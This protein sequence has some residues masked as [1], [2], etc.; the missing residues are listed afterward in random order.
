VTF[1]AQHEQPSCDGESGS[2]VQ[3]AGAQCNDDRCHQRH[4]SEKE[5]RDHAIVTLT[6]T[7]QK[8]Q[9]AEVT[10]ETFFDAFFIVVLLGEAGILSGAQ[11]SGMFY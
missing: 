2:A 5:F 3:V 8:K 6:K 4:K 10:Q 1:C 9:K 11:N 7:A